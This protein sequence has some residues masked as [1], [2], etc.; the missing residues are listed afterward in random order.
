MLEVCEWVRFICYWQNQL[1]IGV[2]RERC[3]ENMQEIYRKTLVLKCNFNKVAKQFYWNNTLTW[4]FSCKFTAYF[5]NILSEDHLRMVISELQFNTRAWGLRNINYKWIN[6]ESDASATCQYMPIRYFSKLLTTWLFCYQ[7][8]KFY[9]LEENNTFQMVMQFKVL[10][11]SLLS[12]SLCLLSKI[13]DIHH[14][15]L[16]CPTLFFYPGKLS[17]NKKSTDGAITLAKR[18]N[19]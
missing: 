4:A 7:N 11:D 2:F 6:G 13:A 10:A 19:I 9:W 14:K 8:W 15:F 3:S 17:F 12:D 18:K 5:Q 1:S 16:K